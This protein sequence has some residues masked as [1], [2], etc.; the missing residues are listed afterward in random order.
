MAGDFVAQFPAGVR[1][2][3][4]GAGPVV[5]RLDDFE[6]AL[7]KSFT[8]EAL[9]VLAVDDAVLNSDHHASAAYRAHLVKLMAQRAVK[10]AAGGAP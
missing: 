5:H 7:E 10:V 1:L 3:V 8:P 9:D 6:Q 4:T 2:A